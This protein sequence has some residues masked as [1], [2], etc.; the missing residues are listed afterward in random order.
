MKN[1]SFLLCS[2]ILFI[3]VYAE[4]NP[5]QKNIALFFDFGLQEQEGMGALT[6]ECIEILNKKET[7]DAL[8]LNKGLWNNIAQEHTFNGNFL[9]FRKIDK[10]SVA[11]Y[12]EIYEQSGY[13][14]LV[15]K[16]VTT[17]L[18]LLGAKKLD[19]SNAFPSESFFSSIKNESLFWLYKKLPLLLSYSSSGIKPLLSKLLH[20]S[21]QEETYWNIYLSGHGS[22]FFQTAGITENSFKDLLDFFEHDIKTRSLYYSSCYAGGIMSKAVFGTSVYSYPIFT[23]GLENSVPTQNVSE[24][25]KNLMKI[26]PTQK[27]SWHTLAQ[28]AYLQS[29]ESLLS[30]REPGKTFFSLIPVTIERSYLNEN[31]EFETIT[32]IQV[33]PL[34]NTVLQEDL[35]KINYSPDLYALETACFSS[36]LNFWD[37]SS[38]IISTVRGSSCHYLKEIKLLIMESFSYSS[39]ANRLEAIFIQQ[40]QTQEKTKKIFLIET[41]NCINTQGQVGI[42]KNCIIF[43][44]DDISYTPKILTAARSWH[45][46]LINPIN[47]FFELD[48]NKGFLRQRHSPSNTSESFLNEHEAKPYR[49]LFTHYKALL[50][51]GKQPL[52]RIENF[53]Q[54]PITRKAF[55]FIVTSLSLYA[56]W[57]KIKNQAARAEAFR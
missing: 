51:E 53:T 2:F 34:N 47:I 14:I 42:I 48:D 30:V 50:E 29:Q 24:I 33:L 18:H 36:I 15:P 31:N 27:E 28:R 7:I 26:S 22:L 13:I 3:P 39:L 40:A 4:T 44:H 37:T 17:P 5:E 56:L 19:E 49:E 54:H 1:F 6:T 41:V 35:D 25:F 10:E 55:P 8:V 43:V 16:N 38:K 52:W 12:W 21:T 57:L 46:S 9:P 32:S 23:E 20:K 11:A 45:V